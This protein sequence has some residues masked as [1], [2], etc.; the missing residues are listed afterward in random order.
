[1]K[2]DGGN[3]V[4]PLKVDIL[5]CAAVNAGQARQTLWGRTAGAKEEAKIEAAMR[6]RMSRILFLFEMKGV[7]NIVLGSFGTGVFRNDVPTVA[8][9]WADLLFAPG[10]R[11]AGSFENVVFAI[12]GT[13]TFNT[14]KDVFRPYQNM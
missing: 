13:A 14:F 11:F 3:W 12:L 9:I 4:E 2:D 8:K 7:R 1:M 5:T 6:E 10:A